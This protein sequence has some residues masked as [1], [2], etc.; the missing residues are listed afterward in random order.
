MYSSF[1]HYYIAYSFIKQNKHIQI[2][3]CGI[4]DLYLSDSEWNLSTASL[5]KAR[6]F[7]FLPVSIAK[8]QVSDFVCLT[9]NECQ[10]ILEDV[11]FV[12]LVF[13]FLKFL[14]HQHVL[15]TGK[16][17]GQRFTQYVQKEQYRSIHPVQVPSSQNQNYRKSVCCQRGRA[18][19]T[20]L[21]C[22]WKIIIT[23]TLWK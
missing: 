3:G 14:F 20:H 10:T 2:F 13:L 12:C 7:F 1:S 9:W 5:S 17:L 16:Y 22:W 15:L 23:Q 8:C 19:E 21:H 6:F 18:R 4:L 11:F